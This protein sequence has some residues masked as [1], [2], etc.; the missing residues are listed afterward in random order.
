MK[1]NFIKYILI[2][3]FLSYENLSFAENNF[4]FESNTIEYKDNQNLIIAKG[5]VKITSS[6]EIDI[7]ADE[8]EYYKLSNILFLKGNVRV[9]DSSKDIVI[10]SNKIRYD[11]NKE[12]IQSENKTEIKIENNFIINTSD[13]YYLRLEKILKSNEKTTLTDNFSNKIQ[14]TDFIYFVKDKK[15]KSQ[16]LKLIDK[17]LNEYIAKDSFIDL[18]INKIAAKDVAVYFSKNDSFGEH[19]RLKG[20][21][22]VSTEETTEIK[23]GVFTTCKPNDDC[24]PWT[25]QSETVV[26]NKKKKDYKL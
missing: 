13:L 2:L 24:P 3:F 23:K 10:K 22:M 20:S 21:Y 9:I 12:S 1:N 16:N 11:K 6:D 4:I 26:H 14:T 15:F 7:F 5:N 19:A 18:N 25:L 17:D 8:S